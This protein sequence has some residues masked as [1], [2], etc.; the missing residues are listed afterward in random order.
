MLVSEGTGKAG[1]PQT[2][3]PLTLAARMLIGQIGGE[4]HCAVDKPK[5]ELGKHDPECRRF[6]PAAK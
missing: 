5:D 1:Q 3:L 6:I 2:D 4:G